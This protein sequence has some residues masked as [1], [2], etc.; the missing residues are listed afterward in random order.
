[1]FSEGKDKAIM[2][3]ERKFEF[4]R[5]VQEEQQ[6]ERQQ[7]EKFQKAAMRFGKI[8]NVDDI[9]R[10]F[11]DL[12]RQHSELLGPAESPSQEK[13]ERNLGSSQRFTSEKAELE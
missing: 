4:M 8:Q 9:D 11:E 10:A 13:I 12:D 7:K 2:D 6:K 3:M 5:K 1:M